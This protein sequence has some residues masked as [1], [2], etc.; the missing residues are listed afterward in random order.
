MEKLSNQFSLSARLKSFRY[1][2]QGFLYIVRYEHNARI[3]L[4][5]SGVVLIMGFLLHI[6]RLEWVLVLLCMGFVLTAE[7]F[8]TTIEKLSD[9]VSPQR[10]E[11]IRV[12]K[13]VSA[14]VVLLSSFI[15]MLAGLIVF[16]PYLWQLL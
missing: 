2:A 3:H 8:N 16:V 11:Q 13:D 4:F 5:I 9:I 1:A 14:A 15:A 7:M 10:N 12:I 6:K